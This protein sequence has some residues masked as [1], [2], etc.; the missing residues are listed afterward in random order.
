M[1]I[2]CFTALAILASSALLAGCSAPAVD[3]SSALRQPAKE[4]DLARYVGRWHEQGRYEQSFQRNCEAVTADY[5]AKPDGTIEV[6]NTCRQGAIDGPLSQAVGRARI[7]EGSRNAKL[8]VSFFGP[9]EGDYWVLDR[10][11][12]Y[13]W[14][15][16]GEGS[17][18][19]LWILTRERRI[20]QS[21]Y[22]ALVQRAVR[23]G[24][25][26]SR[27]RRTAQ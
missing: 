4:V 9:F 7:V 14:A 3:T 24:Y 23:M 1:M 26:A 5:A 20:S 16:V 8:K 27:I 13:A 22:Q 12:D 18:R 2:R 19:Y 15:I 11:P 25:D 17:G 21:A 10:A 6:V